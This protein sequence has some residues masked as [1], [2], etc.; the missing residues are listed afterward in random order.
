MP[1]LSNKWQRVGAL[2]L[3]VLLAWVIGWATGISEFLNKEDLRA[4]VLDAGSWGVLIFLALYC[5]GIFIYI[6][7]VV[8]VAGA[9]LVYGFTFGIIVAFVGGLVAITTSFVI[10]RKVGGSPLVKVKSP[11]LRAMLSKLHR[12]PILYIAI[13]RVLMQTS[14]ALN[15]VLA[16]SGVSYRDY[17][18]GAVLGMWVPVV[19]T[20]T[21]SHYLLW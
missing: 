16:L 4:L 17:L 6:P 19:I 12:R 20:A 7:G 1:I 5:F 11:R 13:L 9:V 3:L 8:F 10:S 14:P 18:V 15:T 2:A 21:A